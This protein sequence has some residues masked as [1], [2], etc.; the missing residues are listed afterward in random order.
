MGLQRKTIIMLMRLI[1]GLRHHA[2][3][4]TL[5]RVDSSSD[6]TLQ[7]GCCYYLLFIDRES[8]A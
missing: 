1:H 7:A 4:F 3:C 6:L 2:K 8:E 5:S